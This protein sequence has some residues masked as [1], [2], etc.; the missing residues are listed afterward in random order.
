M[1]FILKDMPAWEGTSLNRRLWRHGNKENQGKAL[2]VP[3]DWGRPLMMLTLPYGPN[4]IRH[5]TEAVDI[6]LV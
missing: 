1:L 3:D 6:K 5:I 4:G 2:A